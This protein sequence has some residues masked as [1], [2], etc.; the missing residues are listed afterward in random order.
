MVAFLS[1]F[2]HIGLNF[3]TRNFPETNQSK[4]PNDKH[5]ERL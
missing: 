5:N 3:K 4:E 1:S 2:V